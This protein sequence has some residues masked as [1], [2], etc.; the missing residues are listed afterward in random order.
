MK[1]KL[2]RA[3]QEA[4]GTCDFACGK[5]YNVART[6]DLW[7]GSNDVRFR[8]KRLRR[9][10]LADI[11]SQLFNALYQSFRLDSFGIQGRA[12]RVTSAGVVNQID[13][14]RHGL[15]DGGDRR[16]NFRRQFVVTAA[17]VAIF[18]AQFGIG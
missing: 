4:N 16:R 1:L 15:V 8:R 7:F 13:K 14:R 9:F 17:L 3:Q 6:N 18:D 11:L 5:Q 10:Q 12:V 2:Y